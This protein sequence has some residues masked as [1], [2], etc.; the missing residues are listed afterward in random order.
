MTE[1]ETKSLENQERIIQL[2]EN[3]CSDKIPTPTKLLQE[4]LNHE[5][6]DGNGKIYGID[7]IFKD[8]IPSLTGIR[9]QILID[10]PNI[11]QITKEEYKNL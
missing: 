8:P 7:F 9:H 10:N 2:L 6:I 3:L 1:F 11:R 4:Y 5:D